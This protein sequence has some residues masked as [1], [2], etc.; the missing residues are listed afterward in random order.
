MSTEL[1]STRTTINTGGLRFAA[2]LLAI[3]A[4]SA[5][6]G[7]GDG[8]SIGSG[9]DADPVVIDFPIAYVR[10]PLA[11]DNQGEFQASDAREL[12]TFNFGADL[13]FRDRASP[14]A[15]AVNITER[16]TNGLGAVRDVE[17]SYDGTRLLFA[18]RSPVDLNLD[19][20]RY[21]LMKAN[22]SLLR[23]MRIRTKTRSCCT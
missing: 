6:G 23:R 8:V 13:F 21:C 19:P 7:S 1:R 17:I 9:Q 5:C 15:L 2:W 3:A 22:R 10:E 11:V 12:I 14:S 16:E 4:L 20:T 18:M